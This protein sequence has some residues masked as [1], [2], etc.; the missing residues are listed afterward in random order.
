M[1]IRDRLTSDGQRAAGMLLQKMPADSDDADAWNRVTALAATV[2]DEE[3]LQLEQPELIHRLFHEEDVRLFDNEPVAFH[4]H[5]TKERVAD[6]LR[7]LG[8]DEVMDIIEKEKK[9]EVTCHFCNKQYHIDSVDAKQL[10][11]EQ[12]QPKGGTTCH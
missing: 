3:L 8:Y 9:I 10:F 6:S 2:R 12:P 1:C 11:V 4:C 5:C 7:S